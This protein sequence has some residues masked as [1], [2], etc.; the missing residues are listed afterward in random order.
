VTAATLAIVP[1]AD[2]DASVSVYV[3]LGLGMLLYQFAIGAANDLA[4]REVDAAAKPW[5]PLVRGDLRPVEA[6]AVVA[7]CVA[8]GLIVTLA[9][10]LGA[11]LV[12][13]AGLACGLAYDAA[14]KRTVLSFLPLSLAL[15][16]VPVWVFLAVDAWEPLLWWVFPL[17]VLFG[18]SLHL[19]NQLPDL[20]TERIRG[21]AHRAGARR[22]AL[23]AFGLFGAGA[24]LAVVVL[25]F[26]SRPRAA[27][28]GAA[29]FLAMVLAP[30]A[31][32]VFGRDGLFGVLAVTT[33]VIAVVFLSAV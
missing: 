8:G 7:A 27:L 2:G 13:I 1:L 17:G 16:L 26:E 33:A 28:A 18:A 15:P 23:L 31:T 25:L 19:A 11:W 5:K 24:S 10:P 6:R 14:L 30:R 29:A 32:R 22:A 21:A 3:Q 9:L 12:G 20:A 4:D